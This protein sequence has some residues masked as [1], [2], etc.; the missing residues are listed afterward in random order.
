MK[1]TQVNNLDFIDIKTSLKDYLRAK[2]DFSDFDFEGST[3]SNLLDVL[4]YNTYYTAFNTNM[5]V[6]E[7]FLESAT[8]RDN[9][10]TIAK[11]L[12]YKPKSVVSGLPTK[13]IVAEAPIPILFLISVS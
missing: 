13:S 4:A 7:L 12:G 9:V 11:Q 10:I 6:N 2:T 3:W 5:V 1:Y 8:L